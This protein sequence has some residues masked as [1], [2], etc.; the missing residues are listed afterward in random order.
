MKLLMVLRLAALL[1]NHYAGSGC[2]LL[3][4]VV[5]KTLNPEV[6]IPE[7]TQF[8]QEFI[9]SDATAEVVGELK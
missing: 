7:Y 8:L 2:Q 3:E 5:A 4:D 9:D 6:S 1:L